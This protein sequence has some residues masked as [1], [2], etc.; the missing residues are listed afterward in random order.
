[1]L[2]KERKWNHIKLSVKTK[3]G[4]CAEDCCCTGPRSKGQ[5]P[6][7]HCCCL[8]TLQCPVRLG[9]GRERLME[10][11]RLVFSFC[12]WVSGEMQS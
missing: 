3:Q 9:L 12:P 4:D 8:S 6:G 5:G 7:A 10:D 2:R 11:L 1:M